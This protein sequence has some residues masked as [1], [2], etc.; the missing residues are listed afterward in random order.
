M[1]K[2]APTMTSAELLQWENE[3]LAEI[4]DTGAGAPFPEACTS[5]LHAPTTHNLQAGKPNFASLYPCKACACKR[6][7]GPR[8]TKGPTE[9]E[10]NAAAQRAMEAYSPRAEENSDIFC[11]FCS[12]QLYWHADDCAKEVW[13]KLNEQRN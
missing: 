3:G 11:D 2:D 10:R 7:E 8:R 12:M 9:A 6:Y 4:R 13:K 1:T 5:C